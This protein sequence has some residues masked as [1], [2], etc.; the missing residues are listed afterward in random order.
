[1]IF[2]VIVFLVSLNL[3]CHHLTSLKSD[4]FDNL[5][6]QNMHTLCNCHS[7]SQE[8][9]KNDHWIFL[10]SHMQFFCRHEAA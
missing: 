3:I 8:V 2:H 1:M 10:T 4:I 9:Q 6:M 7:S 5:Q